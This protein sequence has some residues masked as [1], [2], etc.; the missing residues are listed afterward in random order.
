MKKHALRFL[1]VPMTVA[2]LLVLLG[3]ASFVSAPAAHAATRSLS[4]TRTT[5][6]ALHASAQTQVVIQY[7]DYDADAA[8]VGWYMDAN[9]TA[10]FYGSQGYTCT[11]A[12]TPDVSAGLYLY[13]FIP[14][15]YQAFGYL[16]CSN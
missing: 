2:A 10:N 4:S 6:S 14:Y 16:N 15:T 9:D 3:I 1:A 12:G 13:N 8:L 11:I 5:Q 7:Y